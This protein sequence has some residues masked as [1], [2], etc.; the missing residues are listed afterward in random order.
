MCMCVFS[1]PILIGVNKFLVTTKERRTYRNQH[2][3]IHLL[4]FFNAE[5]VR[6]HP[7]IIDLRLVFIESCWE[8]PDDRAVCLLHDDTKDHHQ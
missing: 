4:L 3:F 5:K 2:F 6:P 8:P 1:R 7:Y